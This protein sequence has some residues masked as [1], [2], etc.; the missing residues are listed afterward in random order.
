MA[1]VK[2]NEKEYRIDNATF[3]GKDIIDFSPRASVPGQ[4]FVMSDLS[5]YQPLVQT[6]W[7]HGFGFQ[8]YSDALGYL[9]TEG[10]LDTRHEGIVMMFTDSTSSD[11][12]N[13]VKEGFVNWNSAVYAWGDCGL[14]KYVD[15]V[16]WSDIYTTG[17]VNYAYP[18]GLYLFF[19][20]DGARIQKINTS[21]TVSDAGLDANADDY[22]W[23]IAH[24]GYIY[25]S[26]D[27][28]NR[29]HYDNSEDLST[30]E[31]TANDTNKV[32]LGVGQIDNIGVI[33][34]AGQMYVSRKDG[35]WHVGE[36]NIARRVLD[37]SQERS[38]D[39]FRSMA[40]VNG[41]L[42][43]PIRDRI[44]QWNG[45][46]VTDNT[47]R[48]LTDTFPYTTYGR[49]DNFVAAGE[50][51]YLTAR[52]NEATY[53][54]HL[55]VWDGLGWHKLAELVTN[56]TDT[57][58]AMGYDTVNNYLWYHL[59]ATADVTYYIKFRDYSPFPHADFPTT[60]THELISSRMDMGFR[61]VEKSLSSMFIEASNLSSTTY[62]EVYYQI[63]D[64]SWVLWDTITSDGVTE[65]KYPGKYRSREFKYMFYKI[66]FITS[67]AAQTPVLESVT[68][69]FI[70]RPDAYYGYSMDII[71]SDDGRG[72]TAD[73]RTMKELIED[74]KDARD[75]K[76]PIEFIDLQGIT[77]W[78]YITTYN[79]RPV[80]YSDELDEENLEQRVS[81][82]FVEI[83]KAV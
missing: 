69:R 44:V 7:R 61:R 74:I 45:A 34:Y 55:L 11:T 67:T 72:Q 52:T 2:I 66:K 46:R 56:G 65:L 42:F 18:A 10:R 27:N 40:V 35:L 22:N 82:N 28:V 24:N 23:L 12:D 80:S 8:W 1:T 77:H 15:G 26:K 51:L 33:V 31:G 58:T 78:G 47:P 6:D 32:L 76:A 30:L 25:A 5:L 4:S 75:S 64:G 21:D 49:F 3:K 60:G 68:L 37:Y 9:R 20:P 19:C 71:V 79:E 36:D 73:D 41:F 38:D 17:A 59:N 57:I 70:M 50:K 53:E 62:L 13:D 39:N 54:E 29:I 43:F 81:I 16:G 83:E 14:R 48:R 63:D